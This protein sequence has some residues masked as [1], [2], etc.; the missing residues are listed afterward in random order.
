M[1]QE[2]DTTGKG[3]G[4]KSNIP[5]QTSEFVI[6]AQRSQHLNR[7]GNVSSDFV[8][9]PVKY[10]PICKRLTL[11]KNKKKRQDVLDRKRALLDDED[12]RPLK[13][14]DDLPDSIVLAARGLMQQEA[15]QM[16]KTFSQLQ[17]N[18]QISKDGV[19]FNSKDTLRDCE[20]NEAKYL[21]EL[22]NSNVSSKKKKM[23]SN[24]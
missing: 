22:F 17:A 6:I 10:F 1:V 21:K 23:L 4:A 20:K 7:G 19:L 13:I 3:A 24:K 9:P 15:D 11:H 12:Q 18:V 2:K 8:P 5:L 14:S 16:N